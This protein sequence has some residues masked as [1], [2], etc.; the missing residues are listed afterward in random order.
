M[1]YNKRMPINIKVVFVKAVFAA[2]VI[3]LFDESAL[4]QKSRTP[5]KPKKTSTT[6][7]G[8]FDTQSFLG[9]VEGSDYKNSF[10]D[11]KVSLPPSWIVQEKAVNEEIKEIGNGAVRGKNRTAQKVLD[12]AAQRVT[13]LFTATK[14]ILGIADN[15]LFNLTVEKPLPPLRFRDGNDYLRVALQS[16]KLMQLPPDYR[17]SENIQS[18]TF[19]GEKFYYIDV[20]RTGF[21]Q[22]FYVTARKGYAVFFLLQFADPKDLKTMKNLLRNSDFAW[23]N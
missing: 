16:Y 2:A 21:T 20:E 14:D 17:Y 23:K 3:L 8:T 22:R 4:A 13:I 12:R 1:I 10:F 15:A 19:G 7:T 6:V 18:E 5:P 9:T 11:I